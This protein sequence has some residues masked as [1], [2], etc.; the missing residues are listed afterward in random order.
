VNRRR[1]LA[2]SAGVAG[3]AVALPLAGRHTRGKIVP[4]VGE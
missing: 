4:R 3:G 2:G 1:F